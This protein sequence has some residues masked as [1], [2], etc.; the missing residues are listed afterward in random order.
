[1]S[2]LDAFRTNL[3]V[4][5][6]RVEV[7]PGELRFVL[8]DLEPGRRFDLAIGDFAEVVQATDLTDVT[9]V[10][11]RLTLRAPDGLPAGSAWEASI[12]IDGAKLARTT[13]ESGRSRT[14]TDLAANVS[15]LTGAH[16][17]GVRLELV[18]V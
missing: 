15:K 16:E 7:A 17:V 1:M 6:G 5:Q 13:C 12:L 14:I 11:A 18:S 4:T 2:E 8:G 3:G 9:L 10:R